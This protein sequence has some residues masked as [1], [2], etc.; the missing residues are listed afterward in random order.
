VIREAARPVVENASVSLVRKTETTIGPVA[1]DGQTITLVARTR[2]IRI[3][4][5][6]FGALGV[7]ARPTHV[8]ILDADGRHQVVRIRDVE[9]GVLAAIALTGTGYVL[10]GQALRKA[11][12]R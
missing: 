11:R 6:G 3:G 1:V 10:A 12:S 4:N 2:A 8:E 7:R 9:F 5:R